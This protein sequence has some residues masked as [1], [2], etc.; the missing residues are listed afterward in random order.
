M[1]KGKG[2]ATPLWSCVGW[3]LQQTGCFSRPRSDW[4][5]V[6]ALIL[7][8]TGTTGYASRDAFSKDHFHSRQF[9]IRTS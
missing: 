3:V 9:A 1:G 7:R 5:R 8:P 6:I 4:L 2:V